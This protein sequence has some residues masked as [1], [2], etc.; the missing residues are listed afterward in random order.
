M[1]LT[2]TVTWLTDGWTARAE[3]LASHERAERLAEVDALT[4]EQLVRLASK[5]ASLTAY[6]LALEGVGL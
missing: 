1:N 3:T 4:E 2:D 5:T 6:V